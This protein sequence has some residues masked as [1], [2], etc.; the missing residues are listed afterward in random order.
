MYPPSRPACSLGRSL[1]L[2]RCRAAFTSQSC[3]SSVLAKRNSSSFTK[4]R[5]LGAKGQRQV[6]KRWQSHK[7][8]GRLP[9]RE[10]AAF[11]GLGSSDLSAEAHDLCRSALGVLRGH[12]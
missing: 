4:P 3:C 1:T 12:F 8:P 11:L 5:P 6:A 10:G 2:P 7:R 9:Q